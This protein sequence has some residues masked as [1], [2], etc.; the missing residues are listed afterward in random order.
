MPRKCLDASRRLSGWLSPRLQVTQRGEHQTMVDRRRPRA[1]PL[2]GSHPPAHDTKSERW[3]RRRRL[4]YLTVCICGTELVAD[5]CVHRRLARSCRGARRRPPIGRKRR[6][7]GVDPSLPSL[8]APVAGQGRVSAEHRE[9]SLEAP[10]VLPDNIGGAT[11]A[12]SVMGLEPCESRDQRCGRDPG[13]RSK[14]QVYLFCTYPIDFV[15]FWS[16][17]S[18]RIIGSSCRSGGR[19]GSSPPFRTTPTA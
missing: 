4:G 16:I 13:A 19:D 11:R 8:A 1:T 3:K 17:W 14:S 7:P 2:R 10:R 6:C 9:G 12:H 18:F 15:R 5:R